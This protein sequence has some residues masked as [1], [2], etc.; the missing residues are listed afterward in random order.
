MKSR[1]A[2]RA[3]INFM[4][5]RSLTAANLTV[6]N[7]SDD[8]QIKINDTINEWVSD[9][10]HGGDEIK[11]GSN[12]LLFDRYRFTSI[13]QKAVVIR[14]IQGV[15]PGVEVRFTKCTNSPSKYP[16]G[17]TTLVSMEQLRLDED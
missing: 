11:V 4:Y 9:F 17:S 15:H 16:N 5:K 3:G 1:E 6:G 12:V 13:P 10:K 14:M 7:F 2:Y 8:D